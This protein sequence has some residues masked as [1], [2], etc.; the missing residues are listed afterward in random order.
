MLPAAVQMIDPAGTKETVYTFPKIEKN[1][2]RG[3]LQR[4][5]WWTEKDPFKPNLKGYDVQAAA[6]EIA[7]SRRPRTPIERQ[8]V[9]PQALPANAIVPAVVGLD[10][11]EA[12]KVLT[13]VGYQVKFQK[14]DPAVRR[15][16]VY[17]VQNQIPREKAAAKLGT[18]VWLTLYT[19]ANQQTGGTV[20]AVSRPKVPRVTGLPFRDAEKVLRDAGYGVK[21]RRGVAAR[22]A[23]ELFA[24]YDQ[25][26]KAGAELN[27]GQNVVLI[28]FTKP[29]AAEPKTN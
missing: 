16:L 22:K 13:T 20:P 19:S 6:T 18:V 15:E 5:K 23:Q 21:F 11:R 2:K 25:I 7:Q 27:K 3:L 12:Q 29:A 10:Y 14:G 1:P 28:L 9:G 24:T 4:W 26:P 8:P 17:R